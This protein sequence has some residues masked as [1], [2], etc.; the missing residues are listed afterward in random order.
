MFGTA[1]RRLVEGELKNTGA[2]FQWRSGDSLRIV[3]RGMAI[4]HHPLTGDK[5]WFNH[6][7]VIVLAALLKSGMFRNQ[8]NPNRFFTGP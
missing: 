7:Q 1:D 4:E 2:D 3:N 6:S 8:N 5:V